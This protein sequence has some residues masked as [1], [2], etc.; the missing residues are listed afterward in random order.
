MFRTV[1]V[2]GGD[3]RQLTIAKELADDGHDV[4]I[5]GFNRD[6]IPNGIKNT[7]DPGTALNSDIIILPVPVSFD[8][9][10]INMPFCDKSLSINELTENINPLSVVF[11]GRITDDISKKLTAKGIKHFDYMKRDELAI[12]NAVPIVLTKK[13]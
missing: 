3:L 12:R 2:A 11:G 5:Y 9:I 7:A 1:S 10:T 8:N 4:T 6:M 13:L